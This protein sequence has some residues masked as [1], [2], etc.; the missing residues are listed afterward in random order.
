MTNFDANKEFFKKASLTV[1]CGECPCEGFC[2][3]Y[4]MG[5]CLEN[6]FQWAN[7]DEDD[8]EEEND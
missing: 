1:K 7:L 8:E 6:L 2:I 4:G 3:S 5:E